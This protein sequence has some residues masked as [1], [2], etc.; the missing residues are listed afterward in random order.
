[1][2]L[3]RRRVWTRIRRLRTD[4]DLEEELRIHLEMHSEDNLAAGMSHPE[5]QRRARLQLGRTRSI[6]ESI[7]DQDLITN[8]ESWY[9]DLLFSLRTLRED[10][11][12]FASRRFSP[13]PWESAPTLRCSPFFMDFFSAVCPSPIPESSLISVWLSTAEDGNPSFSPC[14][15]RPDLALTH[16]RRPREWLRDATLVTQTI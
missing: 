3:N 2:K 9:S 1:M 15:T 7:R 13:S 4:A 10:P 6:V 11:A 14:S 12:V 8:L 5:A 16:T